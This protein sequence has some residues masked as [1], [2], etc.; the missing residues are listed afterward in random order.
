MVDSTFTLA[1]LPPI[2]FTLL[3]EFTLASDL[4]RLQIALGAKYGA[5]LMQ[6]ASR[7][8]FKLSCLDP[9]PFWAY[10]IPHLRTLQVKAQSDRTFLPLSLNGRFIIPSTPL[11]SLTKLVMRFEGAASALF[12]IDI[13]TP[14]CD[15]IPALSHLEMS[16]SRPPKDIWLTKL[17]QNLKTLSLHWHTQDFLTADQLA[18]LP[19][20]IETLKFSSVLGGRGD[21]D[22]ALKLPPNLTSLSVGSIHE[23]RMMANLPATLT[24]FETSIRVRGYDSRH[25]VCSSWIPPALRILRLYNA[26]ILL[27]LDKHL[28]LH[29]REFSAYSFNLIDSKGEHLE[30]NTTPEQIHALAGPNHSLAGG[31]SYHY[32]PLVWSIFDRPL[33]F[34]WSSERPLPEH[35]DDLHTFDSDGSPSVPLDRLPSTVTQL[36]VSNLQVDRWNMITKFKSLRELAVGDPNEPAPTAVMQAI[37][38]NLRYL[39]ASMGVFRD[40]SDLKL[41]SSLEKL[42]LHHVT[43][44]RLLFPNLPSSLRKLKLRIFD[45]QRFPEE[46][47]RSMEALKLS[48]CDVSFRR[49]WPSD[50]NTIL[51]HLPRS[52]KRLSVTGQGRNE[53]V[54]KEILPLNLGLLPPHIVSVHMYAY[55]QHHE[56]DWNGLPDSLTALSLYGITKSFDAVGLQTNFHRRL[57][58][59][60]IA[61]AVGLEFP[62]NQAAIEELEMLRETETRTQNEN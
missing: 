53:D 10:E 24:E 40:L 11:P 62:A 29:L 60:T 34:A 41:F 6:S 27:N 15:I 31:N 16:T 54:T 42:D 9:F 32:D 39:S 23:P 12:G 43:P 33:K 20:T 46:W 28:P 36:T 21:V 45:D 22:S 26:T 8:A 48:H 51:Q 7:L 50:C 38:P 25:K 3:S 35:L 61:D 49:T 5:K 58:S 56:I 17:P 14:L 57:L 18:Q 4:K 1:S 52:L 37:G 44:D 2:V 47:W 59:L 55:S 19:R 30:D 13:A